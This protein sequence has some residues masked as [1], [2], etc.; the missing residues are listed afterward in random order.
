[1][2]GMTDTLEDSILN[3][4]FGSAVDIALYTVSPTDST[5]GTEVTGGD[6]ARVTVASTAW[7]TPAGSGSINNANESITFPVPAASWGEI[8][9]F[10]II[11]GT[12]LLLYGAVSPSVDVVLGDNPVRF[13]AGDLVVSLDN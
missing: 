2:A 11:K 6:Y 9:A 8:V 12:D 1:M 7:S 10:G 5:A 4:I 13:K 3:D